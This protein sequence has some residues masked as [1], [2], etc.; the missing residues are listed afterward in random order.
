MPYTL[1]YLEATQVVPEDTL[2]SLCPGL[3]LCCHIVVSATLQTSDQEQAESFC[4]SLMPL[5]LVQISVTVAGCTKTTGYIRLG[6]HMPDIIL[7]KQEV[8]YQLT[9]DQAISR[10]KHSFRER[11]V[12]MQCHETSGTNLLFGM[13][14]LHCKRGFMSNR[15]D[16]ALVSPAG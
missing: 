2:L 4:G 12:K 9:G 15:R 6:P 16:S 13:C 14:S 11:S 8:E 3:S 5:V 10:V 7:V 1:P